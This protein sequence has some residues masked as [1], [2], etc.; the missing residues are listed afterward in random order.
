MPL[1]ASGPSKRSL[2]IGRQLLLNLGKAYT[3]LP[4]GDQI[5]NL[6]KARTCF[7]AA[8]RIRTRSALPEEWAAIQHNLGMV[9][10]VLTSGN[11]IKN[12]EKAVAFFNAALEVRTQVAYPRDWAATQ[13][14]LTLALD[15]QARL[16]LLRQIL[17]K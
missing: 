11:R 4:T 2:K 7:E 8:L 5:K 14:S 6:K 15:T 13:E 3:I 12:L 16:A 9:F 1:C 17:S 10:L